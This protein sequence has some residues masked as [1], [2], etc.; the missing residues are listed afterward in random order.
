MKTDLRFGVMNSSPS[1]SDG[2]PAVAGLDLPPEASGGGAYVWNRIGSPTPISLHDRPT[3]N[4][5]TKQK[6]WFE[7]V[8]GQI[9]NRPYLRLAANGL[10][11]VV[12]KLRV[13]SS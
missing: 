12:E 9:T 6:D 10:S 4:K 3:N 7:D 11:F 1:F 8:S 13:E 5:T 2:S